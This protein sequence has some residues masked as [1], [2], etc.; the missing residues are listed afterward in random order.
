MRLNHLEFLI[1]YIILVVIFKVSSKDPLVKKVTTSLGQPTTL[2]VELPYSDQSEITWKKDG[3]PVDHLV[4]SDGSL[5]ITD[6]SLSDKGEYTVTATGTD[7]ATSETV[8][9]T[10]IDPKLPTS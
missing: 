10:V 9:L 6:T 3:S 8:Q 5:Y 2:F 7:D 1:T 4:L